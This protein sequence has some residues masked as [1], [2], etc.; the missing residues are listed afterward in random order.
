M[1]EKSFVAE[2]TVIEFGSNVIGLTELL[3]THPV[4]FLFSTG[5]GENCVEHRVEVTV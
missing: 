3:R 2:V 1:V 4:Y 5:L